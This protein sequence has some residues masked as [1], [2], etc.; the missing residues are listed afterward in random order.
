MNPSPLACT[1]RD[2]GLPLQRDATAYFCPRG[3]TYDVARNGYVNL[4]QPQDRRSSSA[5]DSKAA[6]DAR[7]RLLTSGV[8]RSILEG[9]VQRAAALD[10]GDHPVVVE[11]GSGSGDALAGLADARPIT[12]V[13]IDLST[14]AIRHAARR[15]PAL[16]WVV[17]NADRRLPILDQRAD[18]VLSLHARR[19]PNECAR[20]LGPT[21]FLLVAVPS[22]DDLIE[23]RGRVQ[24]QEVE[25]DRAG[26]LLREHEPLFTL[27]ERFSIRERPLLDRTSL[28][29]LLHGTYRGARTSASD[30]VNALTT[31]T[32]TLAS[33]VFLFTRRRLT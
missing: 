8:G 32:V 21:G 22:R 10:L 17:A 24:G 29:D 23:L 30:R 26:S 28:V 5:G 18:L 3:H 13:G 31:L 27:V 15:F 19:H 4:L 1:V 20:V 16:T 2:C 11:L 25:R 6:V 12:G 9:F 14:A 7:L 33:D